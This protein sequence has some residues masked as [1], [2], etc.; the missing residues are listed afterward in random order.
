MTEDPIFIQMNIAHY[1]AMLKLGWMTKSV[2]SSSNCSPK[3]RGT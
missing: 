2:R 1:G 3:P